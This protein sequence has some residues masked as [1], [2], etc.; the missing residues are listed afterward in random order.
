MA[1]SRRFQLANTSRTPVSY[2]L[3]GKR[4]ALPGGTTRTHRVCRLPRLGVE[5]PGQPEVQPFK[6]ADGQRV[7]IVAGPDGRL[8]LRTP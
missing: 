1:H 7:V 6:P 4:Y 3:D 5:L 2:R 8:A